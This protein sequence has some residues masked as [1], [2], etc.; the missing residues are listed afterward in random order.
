MTTST[1]SYKQ[2]VYI[3]Y[4]RWSETYDL[5]TNPTRDLSSRVVQERVPD[6]DGLVVVEAGCG[7]G[8]NSASSDDGYS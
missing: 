8:L 3:G 5:Q 2:D 6:L 7:T 1:K 4:E